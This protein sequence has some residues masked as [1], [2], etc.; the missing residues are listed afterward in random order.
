MKI[1]P[2]TA[3]KNAITPTTSLRLNCNAVITPNSKIDKYDTEYILKWNVFLS[4][5][6]LIISNKAYD[7]HVEIAAA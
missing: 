5:T 4:K 2:T 3:S 1:K 7:T 6:T